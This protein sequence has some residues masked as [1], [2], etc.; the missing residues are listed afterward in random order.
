MEI[1]KVYSGDGWTGFALKGRLDGYWADHLATSLE[2]TVRNGVHGIVLDLAEITYISSMGI[3]VLVDHYQKLTAIQGWFAVANPSPQVQKVLS[4]T[5]LLDQ[6]LAKAE[7]PRMAVDQPMQSVKKAAAVYETATLQPNAR[8]QC[9]VLGE[10]SRLTGGGF[11]AADCRMA[12]FPHTA[13]GIGL[14][15]FGNSFDDSRQRF[16]EF[17]AVAGAAA[18]QPTDG[19]NVADYVV[20]REALV[21]E[22][23]VLYA[24]AC[25]GAFSHLLRFQALDAKDGSGGVIGA[26]ALLEDCLAI[27]QTDQAAVAMVAESTGLLGAALRK[28]PALNLPADD[29]FAHPGI[30]DWISFTPDRVHTRA[31]ALVVG[32]VSK[33]GKGPLAAFLRPLGG[34]PELFGHLH[35]A[36]F[37]YQPLKQGRLDLSSTVHSLFNTQTLHGVLHLVAD[38]RG[39]AGG[40]ES[41]FMR[42]ACW[43]APILDITVEGR[44]K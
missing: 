39:G 5:G 24:L 4:L 1:N 37:S 29:L 14:G 20:A 3:R 27:A 8:M 12:S 33:S 13:L 36:A 30:R 26:S 16:G 17:L 40:G 6:L 43:V 25:E 21:P 31:L 38:Q 11:H 32:V 7:V 19:S 41:E 18:Y 44:T 23:Q 15:A 34:S 10:P 22:V 9:R 28:S 35:A 2:E 42:G